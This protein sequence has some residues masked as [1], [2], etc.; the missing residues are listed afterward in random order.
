MNNSEK[1]DLDALYYQS[2]S[3]PQ[4]ERA[5]ELL[6]SLAVN[7]SDSILDIGC[8][9]GNIIAELS[10]QASQGVSIGIDASADM[11]DLAKNVYPK[12][13]FPNL[14]FHHR[15]AEEI[16]FDFSF[17]IIVC[18]N[19]LLWVREPKKALNL[20]CQSL[21]P[22]GTLLILTYLKASSYILFLEKTLDE[23]PD[24]KNLSAPRTMLSTEEYRE[25]ITSNGLILNEFRPEWRFSNYNNLEEIKAYIKGWL[26]CYVPLP[27]DLQETFLQKAVVNSQHENISTK[28]NEI[29][30]PYQVLAIKA[31]RPQGMSLPLDPS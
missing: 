5:Q 22:G 30:L 12:S 14:E 26:G 7:K 18:F 8:G 11:I 10:Q 9:P 24:Y 3:K 6:A 15:K 29:V 16:N 25:A 28:K 31:T 13:K 21:K 23:Y 4:Y 1:V 2:H 19:C 17:D 27:K 20:M